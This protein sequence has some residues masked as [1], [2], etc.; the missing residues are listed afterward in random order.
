MKWWLQSNEFTYSSQL[1]NRTCHKHKK[2]VL[3]IP[4]S[5]LI[6]VPSSK[7]EVLWWWSGSR[8]KTGYLASMK[9]WV[10]NSN[11]TKKRKKERKEKETN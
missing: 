7:K 5:W 1:L 4:V 9:P 3:Y 11:A 10:Q 6:S 2:Y 8:S